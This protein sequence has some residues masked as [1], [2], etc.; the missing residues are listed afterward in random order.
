MGRLDEIASG[1]FSLWE[2][3]GRGWKV[4]RYPVV[5]EPPFCPFSGFRLPRPNT[6]QDDGRKTGLLGSLFDRAEKAL[7]PVPPVISEPEEGEPEPEAFERELPVELQTLLPANLDIESDAFA[8]FLSQ[9]AVCQEP[10]AFELVGQSERIMAQFAAGERDVH[11]LKRQLAGFFPE[12]P[13]LETQNSLVDVWSGVEGEALI[14]EVGLEREFLL[15]LSTLRKLDPFI[16]LIGAMTTL[17]PGELAIY[18]V[19][20]QP[21][22][23]GWKESSLRL[24]SD[25]GGKDIFVNR[26]EWV[27]QAQIKFG[28]PLHAAVVRI[29]TKAGDFDRATEIA[30]EMAFALRIFANQDGNALIPLHNEDYPLDIHEEDLLLRQTHRSGMLLNTDELMGFVHFPSSAV[31]SPRLARQIERTKAAPASVTQ[32]RQFVLGTNEHVGKTIEVGLTPDQRMRHM[33]VIGSSG[34][35]KSNFIFN[36]IRED[37]ENGEGLAVFDPHG[38]LIDRVLGNIP[39]DR[40]N[41]VIL[42]DPSDEEYSV[43]FNIL[44][45]HSDLE[46][47]LLSSDL[48]AVFQR[49]STSWGDQMTGVLNNAILAFLESSRG[50]TLADMRRFLIEPAFRNE[51]LA[52]VKDPDVVYYWQKGFQ[53]LSGNKSIGPLLT[54][55]EMF[56]SPKPIRYMVAQKE[57]RL[58]FAEIMKS[59]KIFLAKLSQGKM[60][61]ENSSLMGS[62]L[63]AKFQLAAMSRQSLPESSRRPFYIYLDEAHNFATPSMVE[64]LTGARKYRVGLILAHQDLSQLERVKEIGSAVLGCST[65]VVFRVNDNDARKLSEGFTFFEAADLQKLEIGR[66]I[67]KVERSDHDFNLSVALSRDVDPGTAEQSRSTVIAASRTKYSSSRSDVEAMLAKHN[68]N[69]AEPAKNIVVSSLSPKT[70]EATPK[71]AEK[72]RELN[73]P[74]AFKTTPLPPIIPDIVPPPAAEK[75]SAARTEPQVRDLGRGGA[76]HRAI[77]KRIKETGEAIG[78]RCSI[79]K[80]LSGKGSADVLLERADRNIACEISITTT[81]DHEVGNILKCLGAGYSEIAFISIEREHLDNVRTAVRES[82]G[83]EAATTVSFYTPDEFIEFLHT[84]PAIVPKTGSAERIRRGYKVKSSIATLSPEEQAKRE[85]EAIRS[86]AEAMQAKSNRPKK[87]L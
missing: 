56:L 82:V 79:E 42:L 6:E 23:D 40:I 52:S 21:T 77:Q 80:D 2:K 12:V 74:V 78:F 36:L 5:P 51:F 9:L 20:S 31:R 63:M 69:I 7:N 53:M 58:D 50:G 46:K 30:R 27:E 14:A 64:I 85:D 55:L 28:T 49:L 76:Q 24:I 1:Q 33:H 87:N 16:G 70:A 44:S 54:R 35:G 17:S 39:E 13:F 41:D 86:I 45:A 73:D 10:V 29:A 15:P 66:A 67:C 84:I 60:G 22:Q 72:P 25:A 47:T 4:W 8:D 11:S 18:Q 3:R 83:K 26:P 32:S 59:R 65:R 75:T 43:G 61:K 81:V 71:E 34:T 38:D 37:I 19:L 57:N 62:L 48:V 68:S